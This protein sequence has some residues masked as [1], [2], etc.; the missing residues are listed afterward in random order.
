MCFS[1]LTK[2][3]PST[4]YDNIDQIF[5]LVFVFVDEIEW[6]FL[7]QNRFCFCWDEMKVFECFVVMNDFFFN[8][9]LLVIMF[10]NILLLNWLIKW[11]QTDKYEIWER[12]LVFLLWWSKKNVLTVTRQTH[13]ICTHFVS[14]GC[15]TKYFLSKIRQT[16]IFFY[17][18]WC[19]RFIIL[20][21][22]WL[23]WAVI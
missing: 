17:N 14:F 19:G 6:V 21:S 8:F 9:S 4:V 15:V 11:L 20:K 18:L 2:P 23:F 12:T 10:V 16:H 7:D 13:G 3:F 1:W 5:C 22:I